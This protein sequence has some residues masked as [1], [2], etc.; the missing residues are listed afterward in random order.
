MLIVFDMIADIFSNKKL[1]LTVTELF[2]RN[3]EIRNFYDNLISHYKQKLVIHQIVRL[4]KELWKCTETPYSFL[5]NDT[6][7]T[8]D[9]PLH[10][11]HYLLHRVKCNQVN[12]LKI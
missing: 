8:S 10:F 11:R 5:V 3:R 1:Q 6:I 4:Y 2:I 7:L 12:W 9:N